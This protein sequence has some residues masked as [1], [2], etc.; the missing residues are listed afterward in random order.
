MLYGKNIVFLLFHSQGKKNRELKKEED[1]MGKNE[2]NYI[3]D[4]ERGSRGQKNP[5]VTSLCC[6]YSNVKGFLLYFRKATVY[7]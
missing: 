3:R 4:I 6:Y 2:Y 1:T 5:R 7:I